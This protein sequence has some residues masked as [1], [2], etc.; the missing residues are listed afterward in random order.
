[1]AQPL[2]TAL[3]PTH[4]RPEILQTSRRNALNVR[5][6]LSLGHQR[7]P[8]PLGRPRRQVQ[9]DERRKLPRRGPIRLILS[10]GLEQIRNGQGLIH[11]QPMLPPVRPVQNGPHRRLHLTQYSSNIPVD[12]ERPKP[13]A[14]P[15]LGNAIRILQGDVGDPLSLPQQV[16]QRIG[17][18]APAGG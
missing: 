16:K 7:Q 11:H 13:I 15:V 9:L 1:M 14:P 10:T 4:H 6:I 2:R 3:R 12:V 8:R 17:F 18:A 5:A